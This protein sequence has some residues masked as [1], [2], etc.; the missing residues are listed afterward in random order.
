MKSTLAL[1]FL[2]GLAVSD[3]PTCGGSDPTASLTM[4][5]TARIPPQIAPTSTVYGAIMTSFLNVSKFV[6]FH[7]SRL[8]TS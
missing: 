6:H 5:F 8:L 3:V 7:T 4:Q 1:P 2:L